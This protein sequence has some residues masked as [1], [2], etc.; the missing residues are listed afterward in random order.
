M[1]PFVTLILWIVAI[2]AACAIGYALSLAV[3]M[4]KSIFLLFEVGLTVVWF[5]AALWQFALMREPNS[6]GGT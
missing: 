6:D 2:V 4:M 3:G 1:N 5:W